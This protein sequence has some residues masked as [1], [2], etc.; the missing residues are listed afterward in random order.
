MEFIMTYVGYDDD[1]DRHDSD[2]SRR[3]FCIIFWKTIVVVRPI[4]KKIKTKQ[5]RLLIYTYAY[6]LFSHFWFTSAKW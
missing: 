2:R 5:G 4:A 1:D 3:M 6:Q